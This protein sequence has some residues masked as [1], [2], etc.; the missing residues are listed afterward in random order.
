MTPLTVPRAP[1]PSHQFALFVFLRVFVFNV[2]V[3]VVPALSLFPR[4]T[5]T[6]VSKP[7]HILHPAPAPHWSPDDGPLNFATLRNL[8]RARKLTPT[9]LVTALF[10]RIRAS[11]H[12]HLFILLFDEAEVLA[13][14]AE[15]EALSPAAAA[16]LPLFGLPF[17]VKDN[18][19]V[20]GKPTTAACP[21]FAYTPEKS[22]PVVDK[23]LAAGAL[24][25]GK[26]NLDQFASGL[27][28]VL[29]PFG[30]PQNPFN[31]D[32]VS[33][34]SSSGSAVAVS[35]NLVAFS[36][37]TDTAGSGRVP[38][39]FNNLVGTKPTRGLVS[40]Q[41]VLPACASL[42]CVAFFTHNPADAADLLAVAKGFVPADPWSRPEAAAFDLDVVRFPVGTFRFG[43]PRASQLDFYGDAPNAALYQKAIARLESLG[44]T[45]VE[46]D[47][48]PFLDSGKLLYEGAWLAERLTPIE[49]FRKE[50][51]NALHPVTSS[52]L[53]RADTLSALDAFKGF[54][55]LAHLARAAESQWALMDLL[56]LPTA[57]IL[58]TRDATRADPRAMSARLGLYTNFVNLLDLCA[59]ALPAGFRPDGLPFGITLLAPAFHD[60]NLFAIASRFATSPIA[61]LPGAHLHQ[62]TPH[63]PDPLPLQPTDNRTLLAVVGAHLSGMPLNHQLTELDGLLV[64]RCRTAPLYRLYAL[65]NTTPPKPGLSRAP[66]GYAGHPIDVEVWSL[67]NAAIASFLAKVPPPMCIG[68]LTLDNNDQVKGFLCEPHALQNATDITPFGGWRN[69]LARK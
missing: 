42:D 25:L 54:H 12:P 1:A 64:R 33:G 24:L 68:T 43:V 51:P 35:G 23:L 55:R 36:L 59:L 19:D 66:A 14:A 38:A 28:G 18:I 30:E 40:T 58:P 50:H 47:A 10:R 13:R 61:G 29:S 3:A 39:A 56:L 62:Q 26:T 48:Q 45:R 5:M 67:P 32:Y 69:Y 8:Y 16:K 60:A 15:L 22:A 46:I 57:P 49:S 27:T 11:I 63:D 21:D 2:V 37:G 52:V 6:T 34:G 20:A 65:A 7:H 41:G 44:G 31:P 53:S 4:S 17:A 9:E